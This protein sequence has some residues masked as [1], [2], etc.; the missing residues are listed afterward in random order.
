MKITDRTKRT[1]LAFAIGTMLTAY[2]FVTEYNA[3]VRL[4]ANGKIVKAISKYS[5]EFYVS[6]ANYYFVTDEGVK[7]SHSQKCGNKRAF[8]KKYKTLELIYNKSN[9]TEF[10]VYN[11]FVKYKVTWTTIIIQFIPSFL[12]GFIL[13]K[14]FHAGAHIL[15]NLKK[16]LFLEND[17]KTM[18]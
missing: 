9:P 7:I 8:D 5:E 15:R 1:I 14:M 12:F 2:Y 6:Y 11:D 18:L 13:S 3:H 16:D 4:Q 10:W 17:S